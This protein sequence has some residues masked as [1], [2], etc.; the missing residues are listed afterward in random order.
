MRIVFQMPKSQELLKDILSWTLDILGFRL[1]RKES[2]MEVLTTIKKGNGSCTADKIVQRFKET[3]HPV[4]KGVSALSRG[5]LKQ[6]KGKTP[7]HVNGDSVNA[8]LFFQTVQFCKSAQCPRSRS[9]LELSNSVL[10]NMKRDEHSTTVVN[11]ILTKLKPEEVQLL[12]SPPKRATGNRM[13]ERVQ[14]FEE[15]TGQIHLTQIM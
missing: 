13:S 9:E 3:G 12:V 10:Q 14:T 15:L 4:S 6:K 2:G 8:E 7:I 5:V 11:K 1:G